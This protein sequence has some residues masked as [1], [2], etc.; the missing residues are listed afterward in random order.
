MN[1]YTSIVH[2]LAQA[3][4]TELNTKAQTST[5]TQQ[6]PSDNSQGESPTPTHPRK[7]ICPTFSDDPAW[8]EKPVQLSW[9]QQELKDLEEA[10][11]K[12]PDTTA[13]VTLTPETATPEADEM[14]ETQKTGKSISIQ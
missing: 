1:L 9:W 14:T 11:T 7:D 3:I 4:G 13:L 6:Y 8:P 12:T 10:E 5:M 2:L